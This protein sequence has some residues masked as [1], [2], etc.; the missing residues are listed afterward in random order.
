M[1][2]NRRSNPGGAQRAADAAAEQEQRA[3]VGGQESVRRYWL[4]FDSPQAPGP[5]CLVR[6]SRI[7]DSWGMRPQLETAS[8]FRRT[9]DHYSL[10]YVD[11]GSGTFHSPAGSRLVRAGD[12]I[13]LFPGIP[14]A[15]GPDAGDR[16]DEINVEF[17]GPAF[18]GWC[19]PGMLDPHEPVRHLEPIGY[20]LSRF[21]ELV[22]SVSRAHGMPTLRDTGRLIELIAHMIT[23]WQP[24]ADKVAASWL[25]E[26]EARLDAIAVGSEADFAALAAEFALGE[27]AF[28]K[29]FKRLTGV[30]PAQY[31][32]R[33]LIEQACVMLEQSD[34]TCRMIARLLGFESEFY[35][36]RRF[37]QL[38]GTS[39]REYRRRSAA[40][41]VSRLPEVSAPAAGRSSPAV[42]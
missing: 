40:V 8:D 14:H 9:L 31:R 42:S 23:D 1:A 4:L 17:S 18:D 10:V 32:A 41:I 20:W 35:F 6:S 2:K 21:N 37:K 22:G 25:E 29:K 30:T 26:V 3:V 36:S 28:R 5:G 34:E 16:W 38:V 15:Y 12:V 7:V 39:P 33:R 27:Q 13:C 19:G 11:R 24:S